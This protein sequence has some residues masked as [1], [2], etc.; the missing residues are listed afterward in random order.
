LKRKKNLFSFLF[1]KFSNPYG[2]GTAIFTRSG[3][4]ARKFQ[5][6]IEAGQVGINLPIPVPLPM[7]SFTGNKKSFLGDINFYGKNGINFFTQHKTIISRWKE[8]GETS[9]KMSTAMPT[10]K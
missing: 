10:H 6:E 3:S 5:R 4:H 9:Q 7:L 1:N 2:N 8:E